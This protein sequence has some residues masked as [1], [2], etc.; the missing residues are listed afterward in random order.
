MNVPSVLLI[1]SALFSG[2]FAHNYLGSGGGLRVGGVNVSCVVSDSTIFSLNR[3]ELN[4]AGMHVSGVASLHVSRTVFIGN[5]AVNG[6]SA[7]LS[8][9]A[10][11]PV[12]S[13]FLL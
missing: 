7:A 11:F 2:N 3:A 1:R 5:Q 13:S 6:G 10:R 8:V 4:G 12:L 9:Q